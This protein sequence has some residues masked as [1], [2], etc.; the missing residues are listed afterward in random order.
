MAH[1]LAVLIPDRHITPHLR[2]SW[3]TVRV[4][5]FGHRAAW[6]LIWILFLAYIA[7]PLAA[8]IKGYS[9]TESEEKTRA[10][11]AFAAMPLTIGLRR[12]WQKFRAHRAPAFLTGT[13]ILCATA[14]QARGEERSAALEEISTR[15]RSVERI[16]RNAHRVM[17]LSLRFSRRKAAREHARKVVKCLRN[18]Y[19]KIHDDDGNQAL[20]ELA[21]LLMEIA[22]RYARGRVSALLPDSRLAGLD[23]AKDYDTIKLAIAVLAFLAT[24]VSTYLWGLEDIALPL[25]VASGALVVLVLFGERSQQLMDRFMSMITSGP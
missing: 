23:P 20:A 17:R 7:V 16:V 6:F 25:A 8:D 3:Y 12:S 13:V 4:N 18:T 2:R 22:D 9:L 5:Q 19:P 15:M 21:S 1:A 24:G 10:Y 11:V 14:H